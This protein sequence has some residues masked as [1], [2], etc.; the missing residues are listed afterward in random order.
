MK[1]MHKIEMHEINVWKFCA[2]FLCNKYCTK[3]VIFYVS[4][5]SETRIIFPHTTALHV[6]CVYF[7]I[8]PEISRSNP[9]SNAPGIANDFEEISAI[10]FVSLMHILFANF[11]RKKKSTALLKAFEWKSEDTRYMSLSTSE[12][13][14]LVL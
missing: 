13:T 11:A 6:K 3:S 8:N 7:R 4:L 9:A 10:S 12:I 14:E 5:Y 2:I 1:F